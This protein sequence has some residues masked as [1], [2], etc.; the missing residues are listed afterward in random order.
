VGTEGGL[1][2]R[3]ARLKP[4][5]VDYLRKNRGMPN[6]TAAKCLVALYPTLF[7]SIE[8]A[9][10]MVRHCRG[11]VRGGHKVTVVA[12]LVRTQA[13]IDSWR[14]KLPRAEP[15]IYKPYN[16]DAKVLKYLVM[17]DMHAPYHSYDAISAAIQY[18]VE[19]KCNAVIYLGDVIDFYA[20]SN[21]VKNPGNRDIQYEIDTVGSIFDAVDRAI[22][23]E[24]TIWK[25]GNH[26]KRLETYLRSRAPELIR[27]GKLKT[28]SL[29]E[30]K[31]RGI[32]IVAAN[33]PIKHKKLTMLHGDEYGGGIQSP[34]NPARGIFLKA[35][36]CVV[37]GHRHV[38]SEHTER[39]IRG[40]IITCW[41]LGCLCDLHP[42]Y[43]PENKW[44][45]GFGIL[46]SGEGEFWRFHNKRI[47]K[48]VVV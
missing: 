45:H 11:A 41:S 33:S 37:I 5:V 23:P 15:S 14:S 18:G 17:A 39:T 38:S 22:K 21:F 6:R 24:R 13:E 29:F 47:I 4:I 3:T 26:E 12:D 44:S 2:V 32:E 35:N 42:E 46:E 36:E 43:A 19:Q 25:L 28:S 10:M 7:K 20:I 8:N 31:K 48:G 1:M 27:V 30:A 34:V 40:K 9:R 16:M